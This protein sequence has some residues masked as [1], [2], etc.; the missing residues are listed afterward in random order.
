MLLIVKNANQIFK[1]KNG[2]SQDFEIEKY[3]LYINA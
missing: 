1:K 3:S 2:L